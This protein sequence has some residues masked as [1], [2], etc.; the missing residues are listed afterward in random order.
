M[1]IDTHSHVNFRAFE[2]D[3]EEVARNCLK[4]RIFMINVG[5]NLMT[6]KKAIEMANSYDG[7]VWASVGLHPIHLA[8]DLQPDED[9][10]STNE[11]SFDYQAYKQLA[12]NSK[13]VAIGETGLDY[14][15]KPKFEVKKKIFKEAQKELLKQHLM[16]AKELDKA[17]IL[18]CRMAYD[19]MLDFFEEHKDL[20]P[21][22]AVLHC[23]MAPMEYLQKFL[24]LGFYIGYN[25]IIYKKIEGINFEE[26]IKNTPNERILL[27]T[28]CPYLPPP[29]KTGE[30]NTP[31]GV[32]A[33]LKTISEIKNLPEQDLANQFNSNAERLFNL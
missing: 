17:I 12:Q 32:K 16:L 9:E 11:R 19:D 21:G 1:L 30:R 15:Y 6:S 13:V 24:A 7:G 27:E 18:H 33:I 20:L 26:L 5:S 14:Y 8:S 28:D 25:G 4:E 22:R 31:M 23:Y 29:Q 2:K 10:D 3:R